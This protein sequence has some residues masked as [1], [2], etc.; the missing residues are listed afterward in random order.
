MGN[1]NKNVVYK[2]NRLLL[3]V[4]LFWCK[5]YKLQLLVRFLAQVK[6]L[7]NKAVYLK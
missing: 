2:M 1:I 5:G 4:L 7:P 3:S 6:K